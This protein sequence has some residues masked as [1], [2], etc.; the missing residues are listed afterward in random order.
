MGTKGAL[1][2]DD[3]GQIALEEVEYQG[4]KDSESAG[5]DDVELRKRMRKIYLKVDFRLIPILGALYAISGIDRINL[6]AARVAGMHLDLRFDIGNRYSI[7]VLMF[8]ITYFIFEIPSNIVLRKV[9]AANWL[10]F[11]AMGWGL[12][13]LG[14]G[15][16]KHWVVILVQQRIAWFYSINV[17]ANGFGGLLCYGLIQMEGLGGLRGWRWIF[18]IEGIITCVLAIFGYFLIIDFPDKVRD[19]KS[20]LTEEEVD[21]IKEGLARDRGDAEFDPITG[22]MFMCLAIGIYGYAYFMIVILQGMGYKAGRVFLMSVPPTLACIPFI[23]IVSFLADRTKLRA[24]YIIFMAIVSTV[25]YLLVAYPKQN[26]VRYFGCF[27]GIAGANGCL[28]AVLAWQANN[29]RGQSTR[30]VASGLQV[31]FGAVGGIY[32]SLTFMEKEAPTYF[33]GLWAGIAAQLFI[34]AASIGMTIFHL[35]Q[36]KKAERGEILIEELEGFRYTY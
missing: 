12:V 23:L 30:A 11:L 36:N 6:S 4:N 15:F 32:A 24:P 7:V 8:F 20:F 9:G 21:L 34:V 33:S 14:A 29:V 13:I 26:G 28:P 5:M 35:V 3:A 17:I 31:A 27:L 10:A 22:L 2:K 1:E 19:K 16:A 25:G 18:V